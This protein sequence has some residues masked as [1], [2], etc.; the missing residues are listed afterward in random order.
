MIG[1]K[2]FL[3]FI[4]EFYEEVS[5]IDHFQWLLFVHFA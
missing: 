4:E 1:T 3:C 2:T 5:T